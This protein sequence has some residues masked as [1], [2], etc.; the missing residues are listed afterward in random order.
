MALSDG[1]KCHDARVS[2]YHS[3]RR[4]DAAAATRAAILDSARELFLARGYPQVT[5]AQIAAKAGVAVQTVYSSAG[6]KT[7]ILG[8]LLQPV[9]DDPTTA[10]T[11]NAVAATTNPDTVVDLTATG[12]RQLHEK[13]WDVLYQLLHNGVGEP[14]AIE[15]A[16]KATQATLHTLAK[17][18]DHLTA[19]RALRPGLNRD[20]ALDILAF[21]FTTASWSLLVGD[22]GWNFDQAQAWLADSARHALLPTP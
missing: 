13:H 19:L 22:R 3:P 6:G 16:N 4:M 8:A 12:A 17:T 20:T 2:K 18:A 11:L 14:A 5:V 21:Y 1:R 15:V 9:I 10:E 7:G